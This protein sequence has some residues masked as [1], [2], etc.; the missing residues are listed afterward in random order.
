[1]VRV[2]KGGGL[3]GGGFPYLDCHHDQAR[4]DPPVLLD[5]LPMVHPLRSPLVLARRFARVGVWSAWVY[6]LLV[7]VYL[8][9]WINGCDHNALILPIPGQILLRIPKLLRR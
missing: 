3:G 2:G 7:L 8:A 1:V 6:G 4:P 9:T 5:P